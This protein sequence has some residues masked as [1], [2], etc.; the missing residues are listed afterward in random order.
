MQKNGADLMVIAPHPDDLEIACG[1]T[2]A[3][4]SKLGKSI[5]AVDLTRGEMASRGTPELRKEESAIASGILGIKSRVNLGIEDGKVFNTWEN[6]IKIAKVVR[7]FRPQFV[8]VPYWECRHPDHYRASELSYEALFL[9]GLKKHEDGE[10]AFRPDRV[11]YY[12]LHTEFE[13]SFIVDITNQ[14]ETKKAAL[15]AYASQFGSTNNVKEK[16]Y[17]TGQPFL[18]LIETRSRYYGSQ[19]GRKYGE[20]FLIKEK[21]ELEDPIAFLATQ[22]KTL[23]RPMG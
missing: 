3:K 11:I 12:M 6:Q 1:G 4:L 8:M 15:M 22:G 9:A 10:E 2:I 23:N 19:I 21:L 13:P 18:D 17:I 16:T 7:Q 14:F 20:A 5:V